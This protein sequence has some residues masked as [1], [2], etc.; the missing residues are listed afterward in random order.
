MDGKRTSLMCGGIYS[1]DGVVHAPNECT[2]SASV[3]DSGH[4]VDVPSPS[5]ACN[6]G[7]R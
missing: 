1:V 3:S 4:L 5:L 6:D 7:F 2:E